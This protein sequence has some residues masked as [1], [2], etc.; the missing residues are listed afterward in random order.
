MKKR[1]ISL[2]LALCLA[3]CLAIP[4]GAATVSN[5]QADAATVEV[6]HDI[7]SNK[8]SCQV[9]DR[10]GTNITS[11]FLQRN[12]LN[13][14]R[15]NLAAIAKDMG[16]RGI[17]TALPTNSGI[18]PMMDVWTSVSCK[19]TMTYTYNG[20]KTA[21]AITYPRI[22]AYVHDWNGGFVSV[23]PAVFEKSNSGLTGATVSGGG[24]DVKIDGGNSRTVQ[25]ITFKVSK[26]GKT[27]LSN[28][29]STWWA[30]QS[31]ASA[32]LINQTGSL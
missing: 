29:R 10:N 3:L 7:F 11:N 22:K 19:L 30:G 18:M 14:D 1:M 20:N 5:G 25:Q 27:V 12:Q 28:W 21:T 16:D 31:T 9:F 17:C 23:N 32:L 2:S 13:Y 6:I 26:N 4:A 15:G 8:E 24:H